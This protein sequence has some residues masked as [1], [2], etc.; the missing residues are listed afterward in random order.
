M[1]LYSSLIA[2]I[3]IITATLHA[4]GAETMTSL[5]TDNSPM[6]KVGASTS[7]LEIIDGDSV[8]HP[9][10]TLS[11]AQFNVYSRPEPLY[12]TPEA[13]AFQKYGSFGTNAAYGSV[14]IS[15]PIYEVNCRDL[16]IPISLH[17]GGNGI[18]VTE[19][20]S[21]VG[22]GWDLSV[23]GCINVVAAGQYDYLV[24]NAKWND[25]QTMLNLENS[26]RFQTKADLPDYTVMQDLVNGMGERDF[27]SVNLLGQ[28]F[29]FFINPSDNSPTIIGDGEGVYSIS[30]SGADG[31]LIKDI[32]G[33]RY[34]FSAVEY[35]I[36]DGAPRLISAY[37]L[38]S[39]ETPQGI[40][41]TFGYEYSAVKGLP[42]GY[43]WYDAQVTFTEIDNH[44]SNTIDIP[45]YGSGANYGNTE[46]TK[47]WLKY[48]TTDNQTVTF[49]L[50]ERTDYTGAKKLDAIKVKDINGSLIFQHHFNYGTFSNST[51]G[52]S[53]P[54]ILSY[55]DTDV[56]NK[57]RLKLLS[58]SQLSTDRADSLTHTFTYTE[59]YP[60]PLKTSAAIDLWGFYNGQE[61]ISVNSTITDKRSLIPSLQDCTLGYNTTYK[62]N[63]QS[64]SVDGACRF[65]DSNRILSGTLSSVTYPTGG[66]S[67][68]TFE[69][70]SFKS[71]P[72]Y[73][74]RGKGYTDVQASVEDNNY[75]ATTTSPGPVTNRT[76]SVSGK[77]QG[78]LTV[79]FSA[80]GGKK[81]RDFKQANAYVIVQPMAS[82]TYKAIK[83]SLDSCQ[84]VNMD[85]TLHQQTFPVSLDAVSYQLIAS[86]PTSIPYGCGY[87]KATLKFRDINSNLES[88]GAGLRIA[89]ITNYDKDGSLIGNRSF[90][91]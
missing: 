73:P 69:P 46:L 85:G 90:E 18:K 47:P 75:P 6:G 27:Y 45:R 1:K 29:L 70:H 79:M 14:D 49:E 86:L 24:R 44:G 16:Q 56:R 20:A 58:I 7:E 22:L 36:P 28:A 48:I 41:A 78:Y 88:G 59:T 81:L 55:L 62:P 31:W 71:S 52:G 13:A 63:T 91:Y 54:D 74:L 65:S 40:T 17:Y 10:R 33:Y 84:N 87:V 37:Y 32:M 42:Q 61:N 26:D 19:E 57:E 60:L 77:A 68:F 67:V 30:A 64:L 25:Y 8:S 89:A 4:I 23:G 66:K 9:E 5:N 38:S 15:I 21:W 3:F 2:A 35:N 43:Q 83:I 76:V 82:P 11:S 72:V 39:I 51:V 80:S 50:S 12:K 34:E 53:F